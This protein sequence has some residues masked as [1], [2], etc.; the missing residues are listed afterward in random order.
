MPTYLTHAMIVAR[1]LV[2]VENE[3]A[4]SR[5]A[6]KGYRDEF[7]SVGNYK[8]GSSVSVQLP[9]MYRAKQGP[10]ID[11]VGIYERST[12]I[13]VDEDYHVAL[14]PTLLDWTLKIDDFEKRHIQR[15]VA[16]LGNFVDY[17]GLA[18]VLNLYNLVGS[19]GTTP[20]T[21]QVIFDGMKRMNKESVPPSPRYAVISPDAHAGIVGGSP[22]GLFSS[23]MVEKLARRGYIGQFGGFDFVMDQNM[24]NMTTGTRAGTPLVKTQPGQGATALVV[25]GLGAG[26]TVLAGEV[27]TVDTVAGV[28]PVSGAAW[29]NSE[30]RQFVVTANAEA[31]GGGD[32]TLPIRPTI[33]SSAASEDYLPYQT[34][35]DVPVVNDP[36]TFVGTLSKTYAQNVMF[37]PETFALT[38]VP[39]ERPI[40]A[41]Q[42]VR[43]ANASDENSGIS[44]VFMSGFDIVNRKEYHRLDILF[45]WDTPRPDL[46]VRLTG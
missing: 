27:F 46:G 43:W 3:L 21:L 24:R 16:A 26:E 37:A 41:G 10:T 38:M 11:T 33:Y 14:E 20:A 30:L 18:E 13:T 6:Y 8:K 9:V 39:F 12:T 36:V 23:D 17:T 7:H 42:S 31:D 34:V 15:A 1:A 19:P 28:N 32:I 44:I 2:A 4:F 25:K 29:E 22:L 45:G 35:N 5:Y 40:S